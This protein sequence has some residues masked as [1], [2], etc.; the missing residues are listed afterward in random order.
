VSAQFDI[1]A[2]QGATFYLE[3]YWLESDQATPVNLSA[4]A[5]AAMQVRS[6]AGAL[7]ASF[8]T[9]DA[10]IT[11]GGSAGTITLL[12][13]PSVTTGWAFGAGVYDLQMTDGGGDVVTLLAGLFTVT[14]AVTQP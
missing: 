4:W 10:S 13:A 9:T 6:E 1:T 12:A 3:F 7:L 8:T 2:D 5:S 14:P 11:L